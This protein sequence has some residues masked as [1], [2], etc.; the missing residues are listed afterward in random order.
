MRLVPDVVPNWSGSQTTHYTTTS[1]KKQNKE[2]CYDVMSD[3]IHQ[4]KVAVD[5]YFTLEG[6][7]L[8]GA[9]II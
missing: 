9:Y 1:G 7:L 8:S 2:R 3:L 4:Y 6:T 5:S